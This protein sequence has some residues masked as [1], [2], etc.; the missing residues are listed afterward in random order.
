MSE[1]LPLLPRRF[2]LLTPEL[3]WQSKGVWRILQGRRRERLGRLARMQAEALATA[4][5]VA[6]AQAVAAQ[7]AEE[8]VIQAR[9]AGERVVEQTRQ[10]VL[11]VRAKPTHPKLR[12]GSLAPAWGGLAHRGFWCRRRR[13][14]AR[15]WRLS[16]SGSGRSTRRRRRKR[17]PE[18]GCRGGGRGRWRAQ[19]RHPKSSC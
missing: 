1:R 10:L 18:R 2:W 14:S 6:E 15:L 3:Q 4:A 9:A 16:W 12:Y 11:Q 17:R 19:P 5:A 7:A 8:L 13:R